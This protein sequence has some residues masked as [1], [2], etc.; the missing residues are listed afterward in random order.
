SR[1]W[2]I[3]AGLRW[4]QTQRPDVGGDAIQS[5]VNLSNR[6][7][8]LQSRWDLSS[9]WSAFAEWQLYQS[10]GHDYYAVRNAYS[11]VVD[12]ART[13]LDRSEQWVGAGLRYTMSDRFEAQLSTQQFIWRSGSPTLQARYPWNTSQLMLI[14]KL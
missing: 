7:I 12:Y 6:Q 5:E 11:E 14:M 13:D 3:T 10:L 8:S 1:P 4:E 2:M 9:S